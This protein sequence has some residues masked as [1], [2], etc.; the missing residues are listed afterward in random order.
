MSAVFSTG[1]TTTR[2]PSSGATTGQAV[3]PEPA[4]EDG[5]GGTGAQPEDADAEHQDELE[6]EH[7]GKWSLGDPDEA[8]KTEGGDSSEA[9][10]G[11]GPL[12]GLEA[13][14]S[15]QRTYPADEIPPV[16]PLQA[17]ATFEKI[18]AKD[19]AS[20]DPKANGHK[21][22]LF[23]PTTDATTGS[24][25]RRVRALGALPARQCHGELVQEP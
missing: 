16:I 22:S 8:Y 5:D 14:L 2:Q 19:A 6:Q 7:A 11:E 9:K 12:G 3:A 25:P 23:G 20:G 18:A 13:Y 15:A 1:G 10:V 4:V 17:G 24:A 21:W